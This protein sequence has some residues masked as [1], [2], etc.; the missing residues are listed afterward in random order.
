M[1]SGIPTSMTKRSMKAISWE[2]ADA[3]IL[4]VG[5][6]VEGVAI[7]ML[8][9]LVDEDT[10]LISLYYGEETLRKKMLPNLQKKE[11]KLLSGDR[12]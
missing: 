2:S 7:E 1:Q 4:A 3:G 5:Q 6:S 10:E 8:T 12:H 11:V 9:S